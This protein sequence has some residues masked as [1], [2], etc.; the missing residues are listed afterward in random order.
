MEISSVIAAP[1][2]R[3][4]L[5]AEKADSKQS[6][7]LPVVAWIDPDVDRIG[8]DPRSWYVE[9]FWLAVLGPS[10]IWLLRRL[11]DRIDEA[12]EGFEL[13]LDETARS[14]GLGGSD[15]RHSPLQRAVDRCLRYGVARRTDH[16]GL[17]VRRRL[18][19]VPRR[20]LLRLPTSLQERHRAWETDEPEPTEAVRL[21]RR[22]RLVALDLRDLGVDGACIERHLL[23][24]GVHPATAFEAARWVWSPGGDD[25]L[26]DVTGAS[27]DQGPR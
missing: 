18:P 5:E 21:R 26:P 11:A 2:L 25:D 20:Q 8:V 17:A 15:S 1:S 10:A 14:L 6:S 27:A 23:L 4:H 19:P 22:A 3:G 9:T 7:T 16:Q 13:D 24:R 12:P